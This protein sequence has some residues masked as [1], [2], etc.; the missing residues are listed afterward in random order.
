MDPFSLR[1]LS[2]LSLSFSLHYTIKSVLALSCVVCVHNDRRLEEFS[3]H[4]VF[5]DSVFL[6]RSSFPSL[7]LLCTANQV[8]VIVLE[9]GI[10]IEQ[11]E[12]NISRRYSQFHGTSTLC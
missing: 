5:M 7:L 8:T 3:R 2:A 9:Q 11:Q 4:Y 6:R 10:P 1:S 12:F